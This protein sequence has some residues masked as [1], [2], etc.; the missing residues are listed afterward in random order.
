MGTSK[1]KLVIYIAVATVIVVV[2]IILLKCCQQDNVTSYFSKDDEGWQ[3]LGDA[4]E[5]VATPNYQDKGGN[6]GG[7]ISANDDA[8]GG[9]WYWNAPEKFLGNKSQAY[10]NEFS[11]SLK[12]S[13]IDN[14]FDDE[15]IVL[16]SD[17]IRIIYNTE[18]NPEVE[19]TDYSVIL[20]EKAGWQM[21]DLAGPAASQEDFIKVLKNLT[22]IHIRGEFVVGED[23]GGLDNVV[24]YLK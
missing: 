15:D 22:A 21:N 23:T 13:S 16:V 17:D 8:A 4:Q 5:G 12:Q 19:W 18:Q 24:L 2:I 14:Q 3:I 10:G 6:P 9:V 1:K 20:C 7:Y 11:F